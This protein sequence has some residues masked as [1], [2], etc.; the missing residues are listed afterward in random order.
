M[1][2][3]AQHLV[4]Y[5]YTWHLQAPENIKVISQKAE[6]G[7]MMFLGLYSF[8]SSSYSILHSAMRRL[9]QR[10][11]GQCYCTADIS[12]QVVHSSSLSP[13]LLSR[14]HPPSSVKAQPYLARLAFA[15]RSISSSLS[16]VLRIAEW[17]AEATPSKAGTLLPDSTI[18]HNVSS[19]MTNFFKEP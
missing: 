8:I 7:M 2:E 16:F 15:L 10:R 5:L 1:Y 14:Q 12:D 9:C 4:F 11:H 17:V 13:S 19:L 6:T 3:M 18:D